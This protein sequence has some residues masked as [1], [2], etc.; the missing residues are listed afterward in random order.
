MLTRRHLFFAAPALAAKPQ[1]KISTFAVDVTPPIGAPLCYSLVVP[2]E[3]V[4]SP[5][6]AKGV[7]LYPSGEKPIVL[8]AVDWLGIGGDSHLDWRTRLAQA[9][10]TTPDRVAV[11]T[12]HQHDAPG[13]DRGALKFAPK[14]TLTPA[15]FCIDALTRV[16]AAIRK[17]K[18]TPVTDWAT[19]TADV[20]GVASNRRIL[21]PDGKTFVFQ[22]FTA[23]RNSPYCAAPDGVIDPALKTVSFYSNQTRLA[24]LHYYAT[25]PMSYYGKGVVNP[26]FVGIARESLSG[27]HVYFTGAAGNIGAG[28]YNDGSPENR[29]V[30]AS[31]I[32]CA[33][34]ASLSNES[35]RPIGRLNWKALPIRLAH[36]EGTDF[37]EAAIR[38]TLDNPNAT[39]RDRASHARYLAWWNRCLTPGPNITIQS[40][41]L[42]GAA[43]IHMPGEL[44]VE[45]QL[46]AIKENSSNWTAM[47]AYGDY[48]PMYIGTAV[49]Y[50]QQGYET[51]A[52]SR[53]GPDAEPVLL[54]SI[55]K[56]LR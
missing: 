8:C 4:E 35:P 11:Q 50:P 2:A 54:D 53:V 55:R 24:S 48:S 45:Y 9:A 10:R 38:R 51:S 49:S 39:P 26:D 17:S 18:P 21:S 29:T 33:M 42:D 14:D 22:R 30:L 47:A 36:R 28:K 15:A 31:K 6:L 34:K 7:V 25:H 52:V 44:F 3:R 56:S 12:V 27:F 1:L 23:C 32:T 37:N 46:A 13:D 5:L 20:Q 41:Q 40:L 19:G 43:I 16:A